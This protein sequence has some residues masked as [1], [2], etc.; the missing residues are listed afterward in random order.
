MPASKMWKS[1]GLYIAKFATKGREHP[2]NEIPIKPLYAGSHVKKSILLSIYTRM[3]VNI[4]S[5]YKT[6]LLQR[7]I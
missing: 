7:Q 5:K 1:K 3:H 4:E 2:Q 6:Y